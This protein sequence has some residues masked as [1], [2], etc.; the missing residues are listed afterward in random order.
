MYSAVPPKVGNVSVIP[1]VVDRMP[2]LNITWEPPTY[3]LTIAYYR[4]YLRSLGVSN[5]TVETTNSTVVVMDMLDRGVEY[6]VYVTAVS[7]LGEGAR[8]QLH[9]TV[10]YD[11]KSW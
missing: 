7:I 9:R 4:V 1:S 2:S 5:Y 3:N 8:G 6:E 11:G 10:T